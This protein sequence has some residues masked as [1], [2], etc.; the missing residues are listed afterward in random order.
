MEAAKTVVGSNEMNLDIYKMSE[1]KKYI[2]K[3]IDA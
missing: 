3:E 2:L 1:R